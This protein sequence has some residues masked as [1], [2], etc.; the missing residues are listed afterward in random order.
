MNTYDPADYIVYVSMDRENRAAIRPRPDVVEHK[1]PPGYAD[2]SPRTRL[3]VPASVSPSLSSGHVV[4]ITS[5]FSTARDRSRQLPAPQPSKLTVRVR[6][7]SPARPRC[8]G[9][10]SQVSRG[11][12]H[13]WAVRSAAKSLNFPALASLHRT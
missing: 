3:K 8:R 5:P 6:F 1:L 10:P 11:T 4:D 13:V 2:T 9:T 12:A 7:P